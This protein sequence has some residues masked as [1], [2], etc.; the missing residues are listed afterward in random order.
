MF[1]AD[2]HRI[3]KLLDSDVDVV[4]NVVRE[5][6]R[7]QGQLDVLQPVTERIRHIGSEISHAMSIEAR[8]KQLW[9][10]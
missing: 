2:T 4:G 6:V 10:N 5:C 9:P 1:D 3:G 7:R 8:I